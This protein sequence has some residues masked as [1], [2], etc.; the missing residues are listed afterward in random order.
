MMNHQKY[1]QNN[2]AYSSFLETQNPQEFQKYV[3]FIDKYSHHTDMILDTG[4][5]TGIVLSLLE[6]RSYCDTHGVDISKTSVGI[7]QGKRLNCSVYDGKILPFENSVFQVVGS[8]NVLEHTDD[9]LAFL[10]EEFRV[11][12]KGGYLIVACPNFLSITNNYHYHTS[13]FFQKISNF[14]ELFK[15]VFSSEYIFRK[16]EPVNREEFHPDDDAVNVTNPL[17]ILKWAKTKG[18]KIEYWSSQ[19]ISRKGALTFI[20]RSFFR[21]FLG[22]LF[23]VF[24]K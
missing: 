17:S 6:K 23:I 4:C 1:Y 22:S 13:G 19:S 16:M 2:E 7:C 12:K 18:L 8:Y 9:P 10:E 3:Y 15:L 20:D 14:F 11:L 5:G 24:K 21:I